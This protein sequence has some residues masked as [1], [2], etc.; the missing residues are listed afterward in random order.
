MPIIVFSLNSNYMYFHHHDVSD[1]YTD[2]TL[3]KA[4]NV[5]QQTP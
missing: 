1:K 5:I 3:D 4:N 2:E